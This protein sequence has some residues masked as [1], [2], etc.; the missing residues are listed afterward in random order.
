MVNRVR[1]GRFHSPSVRYDMIRIKVVSKIII[2]IEGDICNTVDVAFHPFAIGYTHKF[3]G[4]QNI[5][6]D[7]ALDAAQK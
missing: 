4:F 7:T 6:C 5:L 3:P 1:V 2:L